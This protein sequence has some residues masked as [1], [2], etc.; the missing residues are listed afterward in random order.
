MTRRQTLLKSAIADLLERTASALQDASIVRFLGR[1]RCL[2]QVF[3]ITPASAC[4]ASTNT[5]NTHA[6]Q[7][8]RSNPQSAESYEVLA[9]QLPDL[10]GVQTLS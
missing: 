5:V 8:S 10:A 1:A 7:T 3:R 4:L 9:E 6:F 2:S